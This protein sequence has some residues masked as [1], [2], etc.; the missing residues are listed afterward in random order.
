V[1]GTVAALAAVRARTWRTKVIEWSAAAFIT[2]AVGVSRL[3]L[4]AHWLSDVLGGWAL[5]GVWRT[6]VL[7]VTRRS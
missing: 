7:T 2:V 3:Y 1:W 4:G 5:G 6:V